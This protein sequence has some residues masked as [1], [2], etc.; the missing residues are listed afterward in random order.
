M[1]HGDGS[2]PAPEWE[3]PRRSPNV[4]QIALTLDFGLTTPT[5][6]QGSLTAHM[7]AISTAGLWC[8]T[9]PNRPTSRWCL[10]GIIRRRSTD[11]P[12]PCCRCL[13][14][15]CGLS[16]TRACR[17]MALTGQSS[18]GWWTRGR[19]R[20][21][22]R[23]P[24]FRHPHTTHLPNVEAVLMRIT[25]TRTCHCRFHSSQTSSSSARFS[26]LACGC[27]TLPILIRWKRWPTMCR[28]LRAWLRRVL[29]S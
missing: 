26:T 20:I 16:V 23:L 3:T 14:V 22:C 19:N 29:H 7:L 11:L 24:R 5:S 18:S 28:L 21:R 27:M 15:V 9:S 2:I 17:T 1:R 12:T 25:C 8:W 10:S 6:S 13:T 4:C